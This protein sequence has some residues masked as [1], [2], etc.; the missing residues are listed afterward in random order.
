MP[1]SFEDES[2]MWN[3]SRW[4]AHTDTV[5]CILNLDTLRSQGLVELNFTCDRLGLEERL[6]ECERRGY[7]STSEGILAAAQQIIKGSTLK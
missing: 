1:A 6:R 2:P 3:K 7:K 4:Q 5:A